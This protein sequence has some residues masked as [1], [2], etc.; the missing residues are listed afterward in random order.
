MSQF[1]MVNGFG[2]NANKVINK[3]LTIA[4]KNFVG[5]LNTKHLGYA[6]LS[7]KELLKEFGERT[8]LDAKAFREDSLHAAI[9][10]EAMYYGYDIRPVTLNDGSADMHIILSRAV[11]FAVRQQRVI[12]PLDLY[13]ILM[14]TE[15]TEFYNLMLECGVDGKTLEDLKDILME[16]PSLMDVAS[17]L[18]GMAIRDELD[19]IESRDEVIDT[20]IEVLGRRQKGNPCLIGEAGVGKTAIIEGLAQRIVAGNVPEYLKNKHIINVDVSAIVAGCKYRGDFETKFNNIL[21]EAASSSKVILFFDEFHTLMG[22]GSSNEGSLTAAN[23]LKPALARGNIRIVGAT[24]TS[25]YKKYIEKDSAFERRMQTIMVNEPSIQEAIKMMTKIVPV[26]S[27]YHNAEITQ[28][29]IVSA[30][31]MSD[32]YIADKKLPDKAITIIDETA[33]RL[34]AFHDG[35]PGKFTVNVIDIKRTVSKLTGIDITDMD[36]TEKDRLVNLEKSLRRFVIGQDEAIKSVSLAIKRNKAGIRNA[37]KP[38]GTFLFVGPTGVG[39]TELCKVLAREMFGGEKSIIRLDMSEYMEKHSVRRLIGAPPGYVGFDD[40][41]QLTDAVKRKPYS[42][43][44]VD[45]IEKAHPDVF[46][47]FLQVMDDGRLTDNKGN[48]IDFK[49]TIIIMT[50]NA[51]YGMIEDTT[52]IMG[53][54]ANGT[55]EI[56]KV[57]EK[58]ALKALEK[59]FRPEFLNRL[60]KVVVFNRLGK[61][62]ASRITAHMIHESI[63][64]LAENNI[65]VTFTNGLTSLVR[66]EGFSEK[67]G[68]RNIR[69]KIQELVEDYLTDLVLLD[70]IIPGDQVRLEVKDGLVKHAVTVLEVLEEDKNKKAKKEEVTLCH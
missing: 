6:L 1:I 9:I 50:S 7:H 55:Q 61:A 34:K 43:I 15:G 25:E 32:K 48:T 42:I 4:N 12:D 28:D 67:Y 58:D 30:V 53:F 64:G 56:V 5:E 35:R 16:L 45:E 8:K 37:N 38:I 2:D 57:S 62:E 40:G 22:A 47:I 20:I 69:R 24:T 3:S 29:A 26:Y 54:G 11:N 44:L 36:K 14:S 66:D 41:G 51:G 10:S 18:N 70:K 46:N 17:D 13:K 39:K 23:M 21:N 60:D 63:K 52:R 68:A 33:A 49:N 59:T 19:P 27:A 31:K 65:K